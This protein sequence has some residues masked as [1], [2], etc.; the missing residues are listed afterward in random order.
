MDKI[1][2]L[3]SPDIHGSR[4]KMRFPIQ[5]R[6]KNK[7][8]LFVSCFNQ[9]KIVWSIVAARLLFCDLILKSDNKITNPLLVDA[10]QLL[11]FD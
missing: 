4:W 11:P 3:I 9:P 6:N 2:F 7:H 5:M 8:K 10:I 1:F